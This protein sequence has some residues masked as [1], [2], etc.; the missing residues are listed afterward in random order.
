MSDVSAVYIQGKLYVSTLHTYI[1]RI[2]IRKIISIQP[3]TLFYTRFFLHFSIKSIRL[4]SRQIQNHS[5]YITKKR[6]I[7][8]Y[9]TM[10]GAEKFIP[11]NSNGFRSPIVLYTTRGRIANFVRCTS[12]LFTSAQRVC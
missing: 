4:I 10:I 12:A 5:P 2:Q 7:C 1:R 9:R 8:D 11:F 6:V 3:P